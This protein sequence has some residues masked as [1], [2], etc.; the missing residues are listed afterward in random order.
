MVLIS[1]MI[2]LFTLAPPRPSHCRSRRLT[3]S[4]RV[5]LAAA[6]A[7]GT[8]GDATGLREVGGLGDGRGHPGE[9]GSGSPA[10]EGRESRRRVTKGKVRTKIDAAAAQR[11]ELPVHPLGASAV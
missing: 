11:G 5:G 8:A 2:S 7:D 9:G 1:L 3:A 6:G 10:G 4:A